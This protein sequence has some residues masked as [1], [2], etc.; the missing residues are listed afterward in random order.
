[1]PLVAQ[2]DLVL[3]VGYDPIEMR[4]GWRDAF[5]CDG[6]AV[7]DISAQRPTPLHAQ[8]T[9]NIVAD[10]G[11]TLEALAEGLPRAPTWPGWRTGCAPRSRR[12][13]RRRGLGPGRRHR[14]GARGPAAGHAGHRRQRRA[15][16]PAVADV[17]LPRAAR[18][19][20][21]LGPLHHGLR[22]AAGHRAEAGRARPAV[23]AFR[24]MRGS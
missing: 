19:G 17:A 23:V 2:A 22:G 12:V 8:A 13:S 11:A 20:A 21:I 3:A 4:T 9:L 7:I 24:A 16:D 18:P 10:T 15:P 14:R 6:A 5:G 1:M